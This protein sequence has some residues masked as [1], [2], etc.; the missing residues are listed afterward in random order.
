MAKN[1]KFVTYSLLTFLI[2]VWGVSWP[3]Y[4]NAV[5]YM[6]PFLFAGFRAF[7]GGI[8]LFLFILNRL[9][10]LKFKEN[11]K[12]YLLSA[13]L[14][15]TCYLG[16]QTVGL[17]FLPGGLFSVLVYFQPV[18]LG[19]LSWW[20][21]KENMTILKIFGLIIGFIGIVFVSVDGLTLHLSVFGVVL[22]LATALGWAIG[23]V[24]VKKNKNRIDAYWMIVMQLI[25]GGATLL[26]AGGITENYQ[27]IVWNTDL[28]L[29]LVWGSTLGMPIAQF[30]YYK[31]MNE[32]EASKVGAFT[33][34]VPII[35]VLIS[36]LFLGE[37]ITMK[38]FIGMIL[39]GLSIYLVNVNFRR[40]LKLKLRNEKKCQEQI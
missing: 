22:A 25:I 9:H 27:E 2:L 30:I 28:I 38:L 18:L 39:V 19:L 21:L 15:I 40:P 24:Y 8:I 11:W 26:I 32:G 5:P 35:S 6:P 34:L 1:Q 36:A 16:I 7:V 20:F 14:N 33:F 37:A 10:L 12:F 4:K 3:I 13:T 31:L 17:N 23:V 29:T